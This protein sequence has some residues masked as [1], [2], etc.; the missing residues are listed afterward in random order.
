VISAYLFKKWADAN[1]V[2]DKW[3]HRTYSQRSRHLFPSSSHGRGLHPPILWMVDDH[4]QDVL[5]WMRDK[6]GNL[7]Q[8]R[9]K[10]IRVLCPETNLIVGYHLT[11]SAYGSVEI[12]KA[13]LNAIK[14]YGVLPKQI[15]LECDKRMRETGLVE[16]LTK[17]G[18]EII[19]REYSPTQKANVEQSF[20][21]DRMEFDKEF[22]S[23][24]SNNPI[25]RPDKAHERVDTDFAEYC[26]LYEEYIQHWNTVRTSIFRGKI[27]KTPVEM[28][29]AWVSGENGVSWSP[30]RIHESAY[31]DLPYW[32]S[33]RQTRSISGSRVRFTIG[34][35]DE[36]EE[37]FFAGKRSYDEY[38]EVVVDDCLIALG[39]R[40]RVDICL[41][42]EDLRTGYVYKK[43]T[44]IKLG[45]IEIMDKVGYGFGAYA[46]KEVVDLVRK[47]SRMVK[48]SLRID[49]EKEAFY[50]HWLSEAQRM[51]D[52]ASRS[53][54]AEVMM[55]P[56]KVYK[57]LRDQVGNPYDVA[58]EGETEFLDQVRQ[59]VSGDSDDDAVAEFLKKC[60]G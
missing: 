5:V 43:G 56:C 10:V 34:K 41:H 20:R 12:K 50:S 6:Y 39:N 8:G 45:E 40:S 26:R 42:F 17:L 16:G 54:V 1:K 32:F 38:G 23:Y 14:N 9:P 22:R 19:G 30:D 33:K 7:R 21:Q 53:D 46:T 13:I 28:W 15:Y 52:A 57:L 24:I 37:Y 49:K 44:E 36:R 29:N 51:A 58:A 25:N 47:M 27:R 55:L 18:I 31:A 48:A 35:D 59:K 2:Y 4:D 3:Y 60:K 11:D